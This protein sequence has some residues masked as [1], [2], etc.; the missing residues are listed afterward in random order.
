M[1]DGIA[2]DIFYKQTTFSTMRKSW[3]TWGF[4]NNNGEYLF[5]KYKEVPKKSLSIF[6]DKLKTLNL[7]PRPQ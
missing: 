4:V 3:D 7:K 2:L 5:P 6:R 1:S